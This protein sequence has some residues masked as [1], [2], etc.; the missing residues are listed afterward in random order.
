MSVLPGGLCLRAG[1]LVDGS[2]EGSVHQ[3]VPQLLVLLVLLAGLTPGTHTHLLLHIEDILIVVVVFV[4][5]VVVV[6]NIMFLVSL[7]CQYVMNCK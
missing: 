4:V 7:D 1:I 6:V 3:G 5:I 2:H